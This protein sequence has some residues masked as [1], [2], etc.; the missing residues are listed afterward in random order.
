MADELKKEEEI[1]NVQAKKPSQNNVR[2]LVYSIAGVLEVLLLFRLVF[3]MSGADASAGF[4]SFIYGV[5]NFFI[6]PY[7]GFIL[8]PGTL[9]AMAAYALLAWG[10]AK[11]ISIAVGRS[12]DGK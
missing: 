4:V 12:H 3:K 11:I 10:I 2:L 7:A 8:E 5:T 6:A 1:N 9:V